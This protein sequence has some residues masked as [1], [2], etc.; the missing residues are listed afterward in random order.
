MT[1]LLS[2][3]ADHL[4]I[5]VLTPRVRQDV[6]VCRV[7]A[8]A[9]MYVCMCMSVC[10][11]SVEWTYLG[12]FNVLEQRH[13]VSVSVRLS[14]YQLRYCPSFK[15]E[16]VKS[17]LGLL[18]DLFTKVHSHSL[19]V[20]N[21]RVCFN[22]PPVQ[23]STFTSCRYVTEPWRISK[24]K[25]ELSRFHHRSIRNNFQ[26]SEWEKRYKCQY[27]NVCQLKACNSYVI[28]RFYLGT[29]YLDLTVVNVRVCF[30]LPPVQ[31]STFTS[32]RYVTE[33][34]SPNAR[35][36]VSLDY[37][38]VYEGAFPVLAVGRLMLRYAIQEGYIG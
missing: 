3:E 38:L 30:K 20:V 7:L 27:E 19:A 29:L 8:E 14:M 21:V 24:L 9:G 22:L 11:W 31:C 12:C 2:L 26:F 32:C 16:V 6:C 18:T 36:K 15:L 4:D 37:P 28:A 33:P 25:S 35:M 13:G 5:V 23:C 34:W 1:H 10:I 17:L